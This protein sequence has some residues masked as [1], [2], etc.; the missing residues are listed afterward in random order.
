[1][2][3]W[4]AIVEIR[5]TRETGPQVGFSCTPLK[6]WPHLPANTVRRKMEPP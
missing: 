4:W 1:M 6:K 5:A 2:I 3:V